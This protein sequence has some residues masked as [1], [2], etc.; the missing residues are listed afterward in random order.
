MLHDAPVAGD[1]RL[2]HCAPSVGAVHVSRSQ[3]ASLDIAELVE[4]EQR[5][6]A[7]A[8]EVPIIGASFLLAI[9]PA[10]AQAGVG[11]SLE[12]M[13]STITFD[14]RRRCTLLIHWPGRS[15]SADRFLGRLSHF[16]SKRPIWLAEAAEPL[17]ARS[18]TTQRIAGSRH[19]LSASFTSSYPASRPNTDWRRRPANRCRPILSVRTSAS[20]S[21]AV[22]VRRSVS[23]SSR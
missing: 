21:A 16:V 11:L 23:S 13:S 10:P 7:G 4:Y 9:E 18:P 14:A 17:I 15:A 5:V 22:S 20:I 6:I 3:G 8:T 2:Q 12:S 19:S 1:Y